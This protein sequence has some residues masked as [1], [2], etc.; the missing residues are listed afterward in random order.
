VAAVGTNPVETLVVM[1]LMLVV[2]R[3]FRN[4]REA[5]FD[6]KKEK[7]FLSAR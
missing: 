6:Y 7:G 4:R 2:E 3:Y 1:G 5:R